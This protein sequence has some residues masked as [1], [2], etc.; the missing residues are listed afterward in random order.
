MITMLEIRNFAAFSGLRI[1]FSPKINVIIGE[2]GTGKT[3]LLKTAYWLCSGSSAFEGKSRKNMHEFQAAITSK[4]VRL[5]MPMDG[6][7]GKMCRYG[8]VENARLAAQFDLDKKVLITFYTNSKSAAV[9]QSINY[10]QYQSVPLFIPTKEVLSLIRGISSPDSNQETIQRLFDETYLDLCGYLLRP[11]D[12]DNRERLES[13]PRF[14]SVFPA[15][16]RAI[17]G[18]YEF[19][20]GDFFFRQGEYEERR[21]RRQNK[22]SDKTEMVFKPVKGAELSNNMTAEGFRKIGILQQLL[23]NGALNPG[24]SGPLFWDEPESNMNPNL[25]RLLVKVLLELSRSGQQIIL[26]THDYV[27][28]KWF[29]LLMDKGKEDHIRF[30]ALYRESFSREIRIES[31]DTY[32]QLKANA[33]AATFTDLYDSEIDRSLG[34][35]LK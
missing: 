14:G 35:K 6:K 4:L 17:G 3:H 18:K 1:D 7:L 20:N 31:A 22:F 28:L 26:A 23:L 25:M 30:H 24:I 19:S 10:E 13:E 2:N 9:Q 27:L 16:V 15:F 29:D 8:A 32:Q 11:G 21:A 34:D 12:L 33:I 5:F